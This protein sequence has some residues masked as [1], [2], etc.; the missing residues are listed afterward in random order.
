MKFFTLSSL[1]SEKRKMQNLKFC[2]KVFSRCNFFAKNSRGQVADTATWI[3]ATIVIIFVLMVSVYAASKIGRNFELPGIL[4]SS[5]KTQEILTQQ[6]FHAYLLTKNPNGI[7]FYN[8]ISSAGN[9]NSTDELIA[10]T[11]FEKLSG[12]SNNIVSLKITDKK[13]DSSTNAIS[14]A[15]KIDPNNFLELKIASQDGK[16]PWE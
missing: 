16:M 9:I 5:E 15:V 1:N 3:V 11:I 12:I 14:Q 4:S 8:Q 7:N 2:S 6:S 10:K 13:S